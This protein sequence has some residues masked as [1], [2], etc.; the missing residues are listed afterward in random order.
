ML[1]QVWTKANSLAVEIKI[2][3]DCKKSRRGIEDSLLSELD[4][5]EYCI[6]IR[7]I[8]YRE[9]MRLFVPMAH[10]ILSAEIN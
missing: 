5:C 7:E 4:K 8:S 9:R 2:N 10:S 6:K 1:E 3:N